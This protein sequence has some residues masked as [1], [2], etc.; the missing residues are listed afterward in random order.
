MFQQ[1]ATV[2]FR[3]RRS[4]ATALVRVF[5]IG[6]GV[7]HSCSF[8]TPAGLKLGIEIQRSVSSR[9]VDDGRRARTPERRTTQRVCSERG[10]GGSMTAA[11]AYRR[12]AAEC[13]SMSQRRE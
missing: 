3:C 13:L 8:Q 12:Y 4:Q 6:C 9:A 1:E 10:V 11:D 7:N 5:S 2:V